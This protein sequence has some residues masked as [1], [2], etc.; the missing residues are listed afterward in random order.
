MLVD[1]HFDEIDISES[2]TLLRKQS[3][4]ISLKQMKEI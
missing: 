4:F 3:Q 1:Q 2:I